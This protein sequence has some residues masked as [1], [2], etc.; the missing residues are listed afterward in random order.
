MKYIQP[1]DIF[2]VVYYWYSV[3]NFNNYTNF[4]FWDVTFISSGLFRKV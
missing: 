2:N 1:H 4:Y 3:F